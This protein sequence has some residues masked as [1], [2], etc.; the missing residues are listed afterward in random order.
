MR[1]TALLL[2]L[3][4]VA[5]SPDARD[6]QFADALAR[7]D[8]EYESAQ[9]ELKRTDYLN[10]S[11]LPD[12]RGRTMV[13]DLEKWVFTPQTQS[14]L[15]RL[16]ELATQSGATARIAEARQLLR[17]EAERRIAIENYWR[18]FPAPFWREHWERFT[19]AN[20]L[21]SQPV[22]PSLLAANQQLVAQLDA[23]EF[24][25]AADPGASRMVI[26]L[27]ESIKEAIPV[28]VKSR[29]SQN[30][31]FQ[32]RSTPC[33]ASI[34]PD[35]ARRAPKI[36]G[37]PPVESFYPKVSQVRGEEGAVVLRLRISDKGCVR[38]GAIVVHSGFD[39]LDSA[40]LRWMET[41][42]YSPGFADGRAVAGETPIKVVF[43]LE[44]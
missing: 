29:R 19:T 40:A 22:P 4:C 20:G 25:R 24:A 33:G 41:A 36:L 39:E 14:A 10:Y 9:R 30:L 16:R 8:S 27:R 2:V 6:P 31:K 3:A 34:A 21:P 42:Q 11:R 15:R 23:G 18:Q 17:T 26:A 1:H 7:F 37:G 5:C 38:A 28:V 13:D 32:A 12:M 44:D 43:R 35:T